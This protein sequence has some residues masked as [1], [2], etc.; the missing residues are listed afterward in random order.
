MTDL[1]FNIP[2]QIVF[3]AD[4]IMRIGGFL[5]NSEKRVMIVTES[6]L[7][8]KK[9]IEKLEE[10]L[11]QQKIN[12][13]VFDEVIPNSTSASV[14]DGL[15]LARAA[16]VD[17]IIGLGGVRTLSAA[18]C[19]AMSYGEQLG[20]DDFLSG[21]K[22]AKPA[23]SYIEI[24]TTCRNQFALTDRC[25]VVDARDRT[26]RIIATQPGI[27]RLLII[28]PTLSTTIAGKYTITTILDT[29]VSS[30]EGYISSKSNYL[31]DIFLT[32]SVELIQ[33]IIA[34]SFANTDDPLVRETASMAGLM[35]AMGLSCSAPGIAS[36][37]SFA[38]GSKCLVPKSMVSIILLPYVLEFNTNAATEKLA[39]IA[40]ILG[41][42]TEG[43]EP[44]E[45][46]KRA[47]EAARRII[48]IAGTPARLRELDLKLE[49]L[50]PASET[51]Y[52]Y[53]LSASL[54]RRPS[55][56]EL[57]DIVKAAY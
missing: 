53:E 38:I 28:D 17:T 55:T 51:L 18:K 7:H 32:K 8:E 48:G 47:Q 26:G 21:A 4:S 6:I 16:H 37:L 19:I 24:P 13:I 25:L 39:T 40:R 27:T 45:A 35:S 57:Y 10:L 9:I 1:Y 42:Q 52:S 36:G 11:S 50:L 46:A 15:K 31:S 5:S 2:S 20:I 23:L 3:G 33:S 34:G 14:E 29:L 43:L 12:F 54:P 49:D 22:P 56:N 30:I 44:E 41:E